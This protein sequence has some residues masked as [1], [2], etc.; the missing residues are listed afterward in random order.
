MRGSPT[1]KKSELLYAGFVLL[2]ARRYAEG[3]RLLRDFIK[4][5]RALKQVGAQKQ[6]PAIA[7]DLLGSELRRQVKV[8]EAE[9]RFKSAVRLKRES[10]DFLGL[11]ITLG[12]LGRINLYS[13][14]PR[15]AIPYFDENVRITQ[16]YAPESEG[17]ARNNLAEA[18]V[19]ANQ[20]E[21]TMATL[22]PI[23]EHPMRFTAT[24]SGFAQLVR[25]EALLL[26]RDYDGAAE[27]LNSSATEF[28]RCGEA[29]GIH[30]LQELEGVAALAR[31]RRITAE[32]RFNFFDTRLQAL[33]DELYAIYR[34]RRR[35]LLVAIQMQ[36]NSVA[37]AALINARNASISAGLPSEDIEIELRE[38]RRMAQGLE[39]PL[40]SE[41][42][43]FYWQTRIVEPLSGALSKLGQ[44]PSPLDYFLFAEQA[45]EYFESAVTAQL[46]V[47][48]SEAS[49]RSFGDKVQGL[50]AIV[51]KWSET[52]SNQKIS[53]EELIASFETLVEL[54]NR[55]VHPK[56]DAPKGSEENILAHIQTILRFA[57]LNANPTG[58]R[59]KAS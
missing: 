27:A 29:N 46:G 51:R 17:I 15:D 13:M 44:H 3:E 20:V 57:V 21:M 30:L 54:R 26:I 5:V 18:F 42:W 32:I 2:R 14:R 40:G 31:G 9:D 33:G 11:G 19:V 12:N 58:E 10:Q 16:Q 45:C 52:S 35:A 34:W 28:E 7:F 55:T 56:P 39:P 4:Q 41:L 6:E 53:W 43:L 1:N 48:K 24:D 25:A 22:R 37:E 47:P 38:L 49:R 50:R 36:E 59:Q 23:F 8:S